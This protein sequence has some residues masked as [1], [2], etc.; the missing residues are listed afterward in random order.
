MKTDTFQKIAEH[1]HTGS[2]K[3]KQIGTG[4]IVND[5]VT[6]T[7]V[8]LDNQEYLRGRNFAD[9]ANLNIVKVNASDLME[10]GLTAE[11]FNIKNNTYI[12]GRNQADS[13]NIDMFKIDGGDEINVGATI[14]SATITTLTSPTSNQTQINVTGSVALADNQSTTTAAV[15]TL[16][17]NESAK[18]AYKILRGT[19][20]QTGTLEISENGDELFDEYVGDD[21]G[22]TFSLSSGVLQYATT[23]TGN[24][25]TLTYAIIKK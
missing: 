5:S 3:G 12:T 10:F 2:G 4:A 16:A 14:T 18:I 20:V 24:A 1:D 19:D 7:K 6:G 13:A 11:N 22:V 15:I 17:S 21:T 23:S 25:A 9:S 8:R